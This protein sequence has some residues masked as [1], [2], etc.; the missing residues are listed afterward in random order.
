[1]K[2]E[3]GREKALGCFAQYLSLRLWHL[4]IFVIDLKGLAVL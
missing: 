2:T 3:E 1:M 4:L